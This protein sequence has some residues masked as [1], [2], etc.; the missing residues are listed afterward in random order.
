MAGNAFKECAV[1]GCESNAHNSAG[2]RRG[3]CGSHRKRLARHGSP[4][5]GS[6]R[7]KDGEPMAWLE[8]NSDRMD[9]SCIVWPFHKNVHGYG[10]V[11]LDGRP[12]L[13][14][15]VM[16]V[17]AHGEP[18]VGDYEAAHSCGN[19][20]RGCVNPAHLR[21]ATPAENQADRIKHGTSNRGERHGASKM[22]KSDVLEVRRLCES[23]SQRKLAKMF[24]VSR[25]TIEDIIHA[26]TWAWV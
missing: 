24:G 2:G 22:S 12:N 6:D 13:A 5:G 21:W 18:P 7:A 26:R 8:E 3:Y 4:F 19:G 1:D 23:V 14:S 15:R 10:V 9:S 11:N 17:K 16:C 25:R 20:N